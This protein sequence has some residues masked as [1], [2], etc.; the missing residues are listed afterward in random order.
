LNTAANGLALIRREISTLEPLVKSGLAPETRLIALKREE[1]ASI[2]SASSCGKRDK[3]RLLSGLDEID[4]QLK[5]EQQAYKTSS[6]NRS[7]G[8]F[9]E[10]WRSSKQEFQLWKA[11]LRRTS[12]RSAC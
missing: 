9:K 4:E 3:K 7:I 1:E 10:K 11:E 8:K 12:V 6:F 5:A 2:G